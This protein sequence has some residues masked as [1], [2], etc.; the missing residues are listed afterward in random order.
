MARILVTYYSRGGNTRKMAES[1]GQGAAESGVE[2]DVKPV[3]EVDAD[4]LKEYAGI[5]LGSPTYYGHPAAEVLSHCAHIGH[6]AEIFLSAARREPEAGY[7]FIENENRAHLACQVTDALEKILLDDRAAGRHHYRLDDILPSQP[8]LW[9]RL[10]RLEKGLH[11]VPVSQS[12]RYRG[13]WLL[14]LRWCDKG[15]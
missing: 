12:D 3:A 14:V 10:L 5:I 8:L 7:H 2:C 1:V 11:L 6:D 13:V 9:P 4:A 15:Q